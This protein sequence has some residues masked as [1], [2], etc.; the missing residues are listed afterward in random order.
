MR[1]KPQE[2]EQRSSRLTTRLAAALLFDPLQNI[3]NKRSMGLLMVPADTAPASA[4]QRPLAIPPSPRFVPFIELGGKHSYKY[5]ISL[6]RGKL[7][8]ILARTRVLS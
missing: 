5:L 3:E 6:T 8:V 2:A 4:A 1:S 7:A